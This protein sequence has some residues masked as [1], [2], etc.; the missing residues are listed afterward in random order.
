MLKAHRLQLSR[1]SIFLLTILPL[2]VSGCVNTVPRQAADAARQQRVAQDPAAMMRIGDSARAHGDWSTAAT[3]YGHA[4]NLRPKNPDYVASY[5]EA[6]VQTGR[7]DDAIDAIHRTQSEA[8]TGDRLRLTLLLARVLTTAQRPQD[9]IAILRPMIATHPNVAALYIALGIAYDSSEDFSGAQES[10][11]RA[12]QLD[13][14]SLAARN[15]LALSQALAGQPA[16]ARAGLIQLRTEAVEHGA[17]AT[18]LATI[19]GNL[20]IVYAM[21]GN[22]NAARHAGRAA[23]QTEQQFQQN[24]RFYSLLGAPAP[25]GAA[26]GAPVSVVA[27][28]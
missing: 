3:F 23:T 21:E 8:S 20:A 12:L 24:M 10:Y 11:R 25:A 2:A 15:N 18:D 7:T 26:S 16:I 9:A 5:A 14:N 13:P 6:L 4:F 19:D 17:P 1:M 28:D 22:L 27:P